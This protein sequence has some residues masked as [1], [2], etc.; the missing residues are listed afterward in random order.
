MARLTSPGA[1]LRL[2]GGILL[3]IGG[4]LAVIAVVVFTSSSQ[5]TG[6]RLS[7][8]ALLV[9]GIAVLIVGLGFR[10]ASTQ[11]WASWLLIVGGGLYAIH[12]IFGFVGVRLTGLPEALFVTI[13][14]VAILA[15]A[16][17]V[18]RSRIGSGSARAALLVLGI[19]LTL[20]ALL[21]DIGIGG[22]LV[23]AILGLFFV[24]TGVI[25]ARTARR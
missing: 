10:G 8:L 19:V 2:V 5:T 1:N 20:N 16:I 14:A 24:G 15:G 4:I 12:A 13:A 22:T 11:D 3:A 6:A 25:I 21:G 18:T 9:E 23:L 7:G 17:A